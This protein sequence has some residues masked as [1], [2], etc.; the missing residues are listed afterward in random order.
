VP[1]HNYGWKLAYRRAILRDWL[2]LEV[3]TSLNFPQDY[4]YQTRQPSWGLGIGFEMTFGS[5]VFLAR[6]ITF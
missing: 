1:L 4:T 2:V 3:R 6:P 5:D